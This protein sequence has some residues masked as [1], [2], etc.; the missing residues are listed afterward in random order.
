MVQGLGVPGI[1]Y[2]EL[3]QDSVVLL[4]ISITKPTRKKLHNYVLAPSLHHR[5]IQLRYEEGLVCINSLPRTRM[6]EQLVTDDT[7][8]RYLWA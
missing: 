5:D 1:Q 8:W 2:L 6:W 7:L 3:S 4:R